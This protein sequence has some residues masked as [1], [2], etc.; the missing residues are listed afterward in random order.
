MVKS[1]TSSD[2]VNTRESQNFSNKNKAIIASN[3]L[4]AIILDHRGKLHWF[5]GRYKN[6]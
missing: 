5:Q 2:Q 3:E 4:R 1:K 6:E